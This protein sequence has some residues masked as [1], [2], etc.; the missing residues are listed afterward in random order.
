M[1]SIGVHNRL[2]ISWGPIIATVDWEC[3]PERRP[4]AIKSEEQLMTYF[5]QVLDTDVSEISH[6]ADSYA[7]LSEMSRRVSAD[8]ASTIDALCAHAT[9]SADMTV[10]A[11]LAEVADLLMQRAEVHRALI[12]LDM[13]ARTEVVGYLRQ[14]CRVIGFARLR[15]RQIRILF[16][17]SRPH[18]ISRERCWK[19]GLAVS[20]ILESLAA[21]AAGSGGGLVSI[22][23]VNNEAMLG[24]RIR[25]HGIR[26]E[27]SKP[28]RDTELIN[29][30][31]RSIGGTFDFWHEGES[32]ETVISM[33]S[34][35]V[36]HRVC[37]ARPDGRVRMAAS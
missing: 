16:I 13:G 37:G 36:M 9:N 33:P 18:L 30:L 32:G 2:S 26:P 21:N 11:A 27:F 20:E 15:S 25:Y 31:V 24:C 4:S 35:G 22:E 17:E 23:V 7:L 1:K 29:A 34:L 28:A 14:L 19:L 10:K 8:Y 5:G 12:D 6:R 3:E